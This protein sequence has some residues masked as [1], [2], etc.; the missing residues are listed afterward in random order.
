MANKAILITAGLGLAAYQISETLKERQVEEE[1]KEVEQRRQDRREEL[2]RRLEEAE[3]K[4][5]GKGGSDVE[6]ELNSTADI[7]RGIDDALLDMLQELQ[8]RAERTSPPLT[9]PLLSSSNKPDEI[10]LG[11]A[12][13][14]GDEDVVKNALSRI[15][16]S[17][18]LGVTRLSRESITLIRD[19]IRDWVAE[20]PTGLSNKILSPLMYMGLFHKKAKLGEPTIIV[21]DDVSERNEIAKMYELAEQCGFYFAPLNRFRQ[22]GASFTVKSSRR[23]DKTGKRRFEGPFILSNVNVTKFG[24]RLNPIQYSGKPQPLESRERTLQLVATRFAAK[25]AAIA[26]ERLLKLDTTSSDEGISFE[27][28][29]AYCGYG[30]DLLRHLE[31]GDIVMLTQHKTKVA[32]TLE[33]TLLRCVPSPDRDIRS[34]GPP[35]AALRNEV[36]TFIGQYLQL[37]HLAYYDIPRIGGRTPSHFVCEQT[38]SEEADTGMFSSP[39]RL[40]QGT[41]RSLE[42]LERERYARERDLERDHV[43]LDSNIARFFTA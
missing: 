13:A 32:S 6:D 38:V 15:Q 40:I 1:A 29:A 3:R 33:S 10:L 20:Q 22:N 27:H 42:L 12:L 16:N 2:Q 36:N 7:F 35:T 26:S 17:P 25:R 28:I 11:S 39:P 9:L 34:Q 4:Q 31:E 14:L 24:Y 41:I 8:K 43:L 5:K 18:G 21:V 30:G 37:L 23:K 19:V